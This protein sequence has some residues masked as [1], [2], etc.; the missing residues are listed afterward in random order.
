MKPTIT[1]EQSPKAGD[2]DDFS[3]R[4]VGPGDTDYSFRLSMT[5]TVLTVWQA[6]S[7]Q[8]AVELANTLTYSHGTAKPF[9]AEGFW[10]DS[11]NSADTVKETENAILNRGWMEFVH[12]SARTSLGAE[13][14]SAL[15]ELDA[16]FLARE[17]SPFLK[18]LDILFEPSQA[19]ED[20]ETEA[21]DHAHFIYRVCILSGVID[22]F[23]FD[24]GGSLNGLEQ[25]LTNAFGAEQAE[26]LVQSFRMVKWLRKQ[27][28]IH[29]SFAVNDDG[30][31][32]RRAEIVAAE[33]YFELG[34][35]HGENW[36]KVLARFT[37]EVR[38][39]TVEIAGGA[40][41]QESV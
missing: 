13:L 34:T 41:N 19:L 7:E 18:S 17:G 20:V 38:A 12:P 5:R 26:R 30:E 36:H 15:N 35:N 39:L 3:V 10:F 1:V 21:S 37:D 14:F 29:E 4:V 31:R 25:W 6:P 40:P 8:S 28:P 9:P 27:Y 22:R 16:A 23:D 11:Y 32:E 24:A 33:Q 2:R